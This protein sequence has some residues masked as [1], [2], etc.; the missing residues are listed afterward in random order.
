MFV[1]KRELAR[2]E[3]ELSRAVK[4]AEKAD[5]DLAAERQ[6]HDWMLLQLSSRLVT[7]HGGYG[8]EETKPEPVQPQQ[9]PKRFIHEPTPEDLDM[10][11]LYKMWAAEAGQPEEDAIQKWEARM[12]GEELF[13]E[14]TEM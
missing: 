12:R 5:A 3:R 11:N 14:N 10:L 1:S 9:H 7:K 8:L 6:R 2:L 4:R 13:I